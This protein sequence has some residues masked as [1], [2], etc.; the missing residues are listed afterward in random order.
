MENLVEEKVTTFLDLIVLDELKKIAE[1][2]LE[3]GFKLMTMNYCVSR[4]GRSGLTHFSFT[5]GKG[6]G[7]IQK[8]FGGFSLSSEYKPSK[9]NGTGCRYK[10]ASYELELED[11]RRCIWATTS[12]KHNPRPI[13]YKSFEEYKN[14]KESG[15]SYM[16]IESK[17]N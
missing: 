1:M 5:D 17:K 10:D 11:F 3:N 9:N 6:F 8:D 13:F 2:L 16:I 12:I 4:L 14:Q 7:Y 15:S